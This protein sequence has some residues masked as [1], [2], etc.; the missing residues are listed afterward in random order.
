MLARGFLAL[1]AVLCCTSS[2]DQL[3][4]RTSPSK[5]LPDICSDR[6]NFFGPDGFITAFPEDPLL[7]RCTASS[8]DL[9][10]ALG[11]GRYG[12]VLRATHISTGTL[13][14]I[15]QINY[16]KKEMLWDVRR[17]ECTQHMVE[18]PAIRKHFCTFFD[19]E[20]QTLNLVLEL[21]EGQP[22]DQIMKETPRLPLNRL[23][24]FTA[25]VIEAV[26]A[27]HLQ[28]ITFC[29]LKPENILIMPDWNIKIIDFGLARRSN[30]CPIGKAF[31]AGSPLFWPP[32]FFPINPMKCYSDPSM[33]WWALGITLIYL[34]IA[35]H[36]YNLASID[37]LKELKQLYLSEFG[38]LVMAGPQMNPDY[39]LE[40][41]DLF[42]LIQRLTVVDR[43][44]RI[45]AD[46]T[47]VY[48][49]LPDHPW[50]STTQ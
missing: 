27:M 42:D 16:T 29:D 40:S 32:E 39:R 33:D 44:S 41:E 26:H 8:F 9:G 19:A 15:K 4:A 37:H 25:T 45:G 36:P 43:K 18:H 13:V 30:S 34:W 3:K 48:Q 12:N 23:K 49:Q 50:L 5:P 10:E 11:K 28:G 1:G 22:L 14:A 31:P 20:H 46:E 47:T 2:S 24:P 21:V 17:E 7:G 38:K 6:E 35:K